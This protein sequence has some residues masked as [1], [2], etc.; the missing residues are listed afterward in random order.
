VITLLAFVASAAAPNS[1]VEFNL[2]DVD[3]ASFEYIKTYTDCFE[4]AAVD[5]KTEPQEARASRFG[6]CHNQRA[7][8][9][10]DYSVKVGPSAVRKLQRSLNIIESAYA[11]GMGVPLTDTK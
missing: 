1:G 9:L 7:E 3:L 4:K 10:K 5:T 2:D 6:L 8:L 11:K